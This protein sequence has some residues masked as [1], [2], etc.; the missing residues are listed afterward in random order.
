MKHFAK[1]L[2]LTVGLGILAVLLSFITN[3]PVRAQDPGPPAL[4][5]PPFFTTD[6]NFLDCRLVNVSA[7]T[8]TA[9]IQIFAQDGSSVRDTGLQS[10]DAG[11]VLFVFA[12]STN[13]PQYCRFSGDFPR[14]QIRAIGAVYNSA[15]QPV[16][17]VPAE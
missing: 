15:I 5:T 10:V 13:N 14:G 16:A 9:R 6:G 2:S 12:T 17:A 7:N 8:I 1:I 4:F 3:R 11:T